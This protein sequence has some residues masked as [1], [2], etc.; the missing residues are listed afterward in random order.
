M[1]RLFCLVAAVAAT[2]TLSP[3]AAR[4]SS[5]QDRLVIGAG[6]LAYR[7]PF[8]GEGVSVFPILIIAARRGA[9]YVD[10]LEVG[11]S[12]APASDGDYAFSIDAFAAARALPGENREQVTVD[13]G[14]RASLD[15]P[16]GTLSIDYRRDL[17][18]EFEGGEAIARYEFSM[19]VGQFTVTPGVQATWQD[20][21]TANYMYGV[22]AE[23]HRKMI[24]DGVGTPLPMFEVRDGA[25]NVGA[26]L[27]VLWRV[28]DRLVA[29]AQVG[30][31][32]L[33]ESVRENPGLRDDFEVQTLIGFGYSF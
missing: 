24:E 13:A 2:L 5:S 23:Q 19:P 3:A 20:R 4:A 10:G 30:G 25:V 12:W 18:G 31:A 17:S 9:F 21:A 6:A 22:S 11:A 27:T 32:Y 15:G 8:E 28:N 26:D 7:S 33:G 29:I 1:H 16:A 14:V